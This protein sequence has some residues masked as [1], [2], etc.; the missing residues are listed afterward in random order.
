MVSAIAEKWLRDT[1]ESTQ[2]YILKLVKIRFKMSDFRCIPQEYT[3]LEKKKLL[4]KDE[5]IPLVRV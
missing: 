5:N 1:S 2:S 3:Y 4:W